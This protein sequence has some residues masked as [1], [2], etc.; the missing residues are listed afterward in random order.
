MYSVPS[1]SSSPQ[2]LNNNDD[3]NDDDDDDSLFAP[4][5]PRTPVPPL[6][7]RNVVEDVL[8]EQLVPLASYVGSLYLRQQKIAEALDQVQKT[9]EQILQQQQQ[10]LS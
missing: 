8:K 10:L 6:P 1:F 4:S 9:Q 7:L 3:F 2:R 5:P